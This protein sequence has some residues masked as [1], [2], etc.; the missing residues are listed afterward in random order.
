MV[1]IVAF[2]YLKIPEAGLRMF[3]YEI[4]CLY[5]QNV[6]LQHCFFTF[7]IN[8]FKGIHV[9]A[10]PYFQETLF[11]EFVP[12]HIIGWWGKA[13]MIRNQALLWVLSIGFEMM[14]VRFFITYEFHAVISIDTRPFKCL[15][16]SNSLI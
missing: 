5:T 12:A 6:L 3:M 2:I 15:P 13:I 9:L 10:S 8:N 4:F 1:L 7:C 16:L 11:D 14:E